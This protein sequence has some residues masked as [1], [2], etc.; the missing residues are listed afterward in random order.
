MLQDAVKNS[1]EQGYHKDN[2][3]GNYRGG[4]NYRGGGNY[5]RFVWINDCNE[6]NSFCFMIFGNISIIQQLLMNRLLLALTHT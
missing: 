6:S 4:N 5:N 3:S 1:K 2:Q